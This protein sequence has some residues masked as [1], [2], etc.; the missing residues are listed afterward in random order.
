MSSFFSKWGW[1]IIT[2]AVALVFSAGKWT[3]SGET[4]MD[5]F[6]QFRIHQVQH[7]QKVDQQ[8]QDMNSNITRLDQHVTDLTTEIKSK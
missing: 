6:D 3:G 5:G 7:D 8:L 1:L 4:R 2:S